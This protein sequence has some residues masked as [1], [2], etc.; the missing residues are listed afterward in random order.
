[1]RGA[2]KSAGVA[3]TLNRLGSLG[4]GFFTKG[5]VTDLESAARA[6]T[7]AYAV[8]FREMLKKGVYLAPSQ[9]EAFFTGAAH[10][11]EDL[12][13]TIEAA[14]HAMKVVAQNCASV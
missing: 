10:E 8:F 6:D 4:C 14:F 9:F 2:A 7:E 13:L 1:L 5:P 12:D 3:V 11:R